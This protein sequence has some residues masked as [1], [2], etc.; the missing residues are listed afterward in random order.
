ML[1]SLDGVTVVIRHTYTLTVNN[2]KT[3]KNMGG[4]CF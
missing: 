2:Y 3:G 1:L 4:S